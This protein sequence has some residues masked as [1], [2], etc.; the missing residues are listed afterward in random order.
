MNAIRWGMIG[1]GDVAE[2]KS[3]P[4]FQKAR[5]SALVAVMR[6]DSAKAE[7]YARRHGVPRVHTT[8]D[9]LIRDP[10]VDAVYV[11]TPPAS[12]WELASRVADARKPCLVEKPMAASFA[13]CTRMLE[14]F[15]RASVPLWVAYYRRALPRFLLLRDL[16]QSGSIGRVTSVQIELRQPLTDRQA[17]QAW[18]FNR[19]LAGGGL[20]YDMGSHA[21]D[22]LDFLFGPVEQASGVTMN[23]GGTYELEDVTAAT[24]RMASGVAATGV[25]NF[26]AGVSSDTL[27]VTTSDGE[28]RTAI[29]DDVDLVVTRAGKREVHPVRNPPHV[30]QPLIQTIVDEL[31]G[32]GICESTGASGA[33]ASRVLEM[34]AALPLSRPGHRR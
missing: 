18:R 13:E 10:D 22:L 16:V 7:D 4:G 1:C 11:A 32:R 5:G 33:R 12:H 30:H 20:F 31:A 17:A 2:V 15:N 21:V 34:C 8:A 14:A 27:V 24:F 25:W 29:F 23:T 19:A 9:D 28:L 3:G 6:R 26:N